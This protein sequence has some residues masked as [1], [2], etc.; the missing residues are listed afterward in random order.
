MQ[1]NSEDPDQT[2][3]LWRLIWVCTIC[4]CPT[5]KALGI[6]GLKCNKIRVAIIRVAEIGKYIVEK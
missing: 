3:I 6:H 2:L 1:A 4:L 5:K